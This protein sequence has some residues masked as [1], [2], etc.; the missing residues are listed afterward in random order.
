MQR[1]REFAKPYQGKFFKEQGFAILISD[2][3]L[4]LLVSGISTR[5]STDQVR[6][7]KNLLPAGDH[8]TPTASIGWHMNTG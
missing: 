3:T 4:D 8:P 1:N 7:Q 2:R 5:R 6:D